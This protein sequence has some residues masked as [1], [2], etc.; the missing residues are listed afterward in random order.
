MM[1]QE[2][3]LKEI[4]R[5]AYLS[6]HQDGLLDIFLGLGI[7]IFGIGMAT[8]I[9]GYIGGLLGALAIP[10]WAAAKKLITIPRLGMVKFGAERKIRIEK[11]KRFFRIFLAVALL[12]GAALFIPLYAK[13]IPLWLHAWLKKFIF[14]PMGLIG[15]VGFGFLA[16]WKQID[17]YYAY[18][19]LVLI[20]V[21]VRPVLSAPASQYLISLGL[22][23]LLSG[24]AVLLRFLR[25]YP[26]PAGETPDVNS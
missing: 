13:S 4:E 25:R 1:A 19:V 6:Y 17:R 9:A 10:S 5:K 22:I 8:D 26:V 7:L 2:I 15:V 20:A 21:L 23:I 12:A 16:Y 18:A 11:E 14:A 3:N 24:L